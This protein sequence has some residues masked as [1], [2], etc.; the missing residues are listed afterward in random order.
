[1]AFAEPGGAPVTGS[2]D[3]VLVGPEGG[4]TPAEL[5]LAEATVDLGPHVYRAETA[6]IA[7]GVLMAALRSGTIA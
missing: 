1:M 4:W 5:D 2:L 7:A 6:A 3:W